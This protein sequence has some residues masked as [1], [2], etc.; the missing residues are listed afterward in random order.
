M[1]EGRNHGGEGGGV[2]NTAGQKY[3]LQLR[4]SRS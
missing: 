3:V 4:S 2:E 1:G